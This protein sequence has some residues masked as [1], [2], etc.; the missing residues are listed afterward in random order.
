MMEAPLCIY[1]QAPAD[2]LEHPLPA[3][4]GE[5]EDAPLRLTTGSTWL[6]THPLPTAKLLR[7]TPA[8]IAGASHRKEDIVVT[9]IAYI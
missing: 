8:T 9:C 3:A 2:S 5:F 4:F 1:C 6:K 7:T